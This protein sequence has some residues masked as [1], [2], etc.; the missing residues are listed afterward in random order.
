MFEEKKAQI[1][2][3]SAPFKIEVY[4]TS[5]WD[6]TLYQAWSKIAH[7]LIPKIDKIEEGLKQLCKLCAA[8]EL[9]LFERSTFLEISHIEAKPHK[10]P[11]R[12]E[13]ISN[14]IKQFKLSLFATNYQFQEMMVKNSKFRAYLLEFTKST[15]LMVIISNT[16][17]EETALK[18]NI[19]ALRPYYEKIVSGTI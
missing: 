15:Y 5:I 1:I 10:D 4:R 7:C 8:D 14:I 19:D 9:V 12:F 2:E 18:I 16:D 13:K 17:V 11:H 6:E 3:K